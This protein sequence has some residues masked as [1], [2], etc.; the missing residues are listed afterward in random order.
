MQRSLLDY[1]PD[2]LLYWDC[3]NEE[4]PENYSKSSGKTEKELADMNGLIRIWDSGKIVFEKT[5]DSSK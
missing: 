3:D 5:Y 2:S 1:R 4:T